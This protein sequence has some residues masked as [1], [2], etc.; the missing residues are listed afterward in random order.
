[1]DALGNLEVWKRSCRLSVRV[2]KEFAACR[3]R[4]FKDQVTRAALSIASNIAEGYERGSNR[5]CARLLRIAR[6]SC[7]ELWT[8]VWIGSQAGFLEQRAARELADEVKEISK[9]LHGLIRFYQLRSK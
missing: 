7:G 1:M 8:Q 2:Y 4:S 3:N 5:D 9:M 6:G